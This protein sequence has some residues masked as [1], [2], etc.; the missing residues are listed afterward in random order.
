MRELMI[1]NR[2]QCEGCGSEIGGCSLREMYVY[3]NDKE[4]LNRLVEC[5]CVLCIV[6]M[7]CPT[8]CNAWFEHYSHGRIWPNTKENIQKLIHT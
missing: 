4:T 7:I 1:F 3:H 8:Y 6:K 2:K 5:P